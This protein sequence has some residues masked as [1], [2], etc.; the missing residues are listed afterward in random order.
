L[1]TIKNVPIAEM[2]LAHFLFYRQGEKSDDESGDGKKWADFG[3]F[4]IFSG[5]RGQKGEIVGT[6]S[7]QK[8]IE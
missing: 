7:R 5:R 8:G 3:F 6:H 1:L 4:D 2:R